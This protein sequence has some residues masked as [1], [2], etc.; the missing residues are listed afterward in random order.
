MTAP[1]SGRSLL[2]E[3]QQLSVKAGPV[4]SI[5]QLTRNDP[6]LGVELAEA[7]A[8]PLLTSTAISLALKGRGIHVGS[9]ALQRHK[10]RACKCP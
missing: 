9:D 1:A 5:N 8:S 10:R 6:S 3:A 7:M 2:Q 4:C